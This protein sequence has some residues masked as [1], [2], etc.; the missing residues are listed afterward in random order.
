MNATDALWAPLI[1]LGFLS[2]GII[3][4]VLVALAA[5]WLANRW[6]DRQLARMVREP[7]P[8]KKLRL[9]LEAIYALPA[10][11]NGERKP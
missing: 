3:A 4:V 2:A 6:E 10:A 1:I 8:Q 5:E 11:K 7:E 9:E